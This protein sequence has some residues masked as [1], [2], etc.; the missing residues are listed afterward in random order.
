MAHRIKYVLAAAVFVFSACVTVNI[1]FPAAEVREAAEEIVGDIRGRDAGGGVQGGETAPGPGSRL[2]LTAP[3]YA[4]QEL[5]VSNTNIR[6]IKEKMKARYSALVPYLKKGVIGENV[7]GELVMKDITALNLRGRAEVKRLVS[8][9]NADREKLY[10]AVS[11]ALRIPTS[12]LHRV[13]KI[14][15]AEWQKTA[16]GGTWIE[17]QAG[18]WKRK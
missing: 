11:N 18:R 6:K 10:R 1:Y 14:F 17:P 15:A 8:S 13:R 12:E 4:Q 2:N 16:P 9:E 7:S 5:T 3:V